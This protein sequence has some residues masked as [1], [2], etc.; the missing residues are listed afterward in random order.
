MLDK[1][2]KILLIMLLLLLLLFSFSCG[3]R[4]GKEELKMDNIESFKLLKKIKSEFEVFC[5]NYDWCQDCPYVG[6]SGGVE[7]C[8]GLYIINYLNQNLS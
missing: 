7:N 1:I 6:V 4:E 3:Y 8:L 5:N 2:L